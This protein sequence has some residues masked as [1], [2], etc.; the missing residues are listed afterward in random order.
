[1]KIVNTWKIIIAATVS[2]S[3]LFFIAPSFAVKSAPE[4]RKLG[5][6]YRNQ[7]QHEKAID[8]MQKSVEL[9]PDN[10]NGLVNLGWTQHLAGK[11]KDAIISLWQAIYIDPFFVPSYN[12][13]GIVYLVDSQLITAL[14]IH[15]IAAVL[16]P[17]N[18]IAFYNLSLTLHRLKAYDLAI[19]TGNYAAILEPL[20][21]HPLVSSAISYWDFNRK[22]TAKQLY[23]KAIKLDIRYKTPS[24]LHH[25]RKAAFTKEQIDTTKQVLSST[26]EQ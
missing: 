1:M 10:V 2:S 25:L 14:L 24:F 23:R 4:Y 19:A 20:N 5:L 8:V 15:T 6:S 3:L 18:E 16:K 13:L 21:P 22:S 17:D 7:G 11:E 12:A 9:E 26:L